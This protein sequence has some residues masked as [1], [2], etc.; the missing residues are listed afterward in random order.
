MLVIQNI[1]VM[2]NSL[3]TSPYIKERKTLG[4]TQLQTL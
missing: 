4:L 1:K 2:A 3:W